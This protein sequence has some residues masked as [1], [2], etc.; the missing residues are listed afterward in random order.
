MSAVCSRHWVPTERHDS[1]AHWTAA[2][3]EWAR[4]S[5]LVQPQPTVKVLIN[6]QIRSRP[7]SAELKVL[8][9]LPWESAG[10]SKSLPFLVIKCEP[11]TISV[12]GC[13]DR[14]TVSTH[15]LWRRAGF[16]WRVQ[17][18]QLTTSQPTWGN[19]AS[20]GPN[21]AVW[22]ATFAWGSPANRR[23]VA[24]TKY[25]PLHDADAV[26]AR[27]VTAHRLSIGTTAVGSVLRTMS[28]F[29]ILERSVVLESPSLAA[30]PLRPPTTQ[31][32]S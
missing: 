6:E 2:P 1:A 21:T 14:H 26:R 20:R 19:V 32:E 29:C 16:V 10:V 7:L 30:A 23:D 27:D 28:S 22:K 18:C 5:L 4:S 24:D 13:I 12:L 11:P 9:L 31:L 25:R 17:I 3:Q 8:A 15:C